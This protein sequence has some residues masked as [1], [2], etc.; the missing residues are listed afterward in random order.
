MSDASDARLSSTVI[1]AREGQR[2]P[3]Y[4]LVRRVTQAAFGGAHVF[5]GGVVE[6]DADRAAGT[7]S[8]LA[9]SLADRRL[10]TPDALRFY[11]AAIR[12]LFEET[13][14]LLGDGDVTARAVLRQELLADCARWPD[15]L[16]R[17]NIRPAYDRLCY[18]SEW[19]TP[20]D[21][22]TRFATRFFVTAFDNRQ[23]ATPCGEELTDCCWMTAAAAL[24]AGDRQ[25]ILLHPPTRLTLEQ[26][27][28]HATIESLIDW[29][30]GLESSGAP[31]IAAAKA[32]LASV[33]QMLSGD[34]AEAVP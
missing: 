31:S 32:T 25:S 3:E 2:E 27:A 11:S 30:R 22:P 15:L 12:E 17:N 34:T 16:R 14:I 20:P 33:R 4:L 29:A 28:R 1:L 24:D 10:S 8:S 13:G 26:L 7:P 23:E 18:I 19:I 5:P 6:P 9:P 21:L